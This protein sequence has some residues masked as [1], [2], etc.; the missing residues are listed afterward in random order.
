M[1]DPDPLRVIVISH[2]GQ[3]LCSAVELEGARLLL[4]GV[5][6]P[7]AVTTATSYG[8]IACCYR[9]VASAGTNPTTVQWQQAT[10]Q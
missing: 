9:D 7:D 8:D 2:K 1:L 10:A 5:S 6:A 4:L 3:S